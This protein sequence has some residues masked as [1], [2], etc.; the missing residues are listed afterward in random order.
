MK[1]YDDKR[2]C[3]GI[4]FIKS[5]MSVSN[6]NKKKELDLENAFKAGIACEQTVIDD[7][8]S[9]SVDRPQMRQLVEILETA[10]YDA[11]VVE[12]IYELTRDLQDLRVL[13]DRINGFGVIIFD[14]STMSAR[15]NN[16]AIEC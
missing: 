9:L 16:Y 13:M 8:I 2:I 1:K 7:G 12:D 5:M 15:Y 14:L 3:K 6:V 10:D 4:L 11:L